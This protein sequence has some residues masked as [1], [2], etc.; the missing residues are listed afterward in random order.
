MGPHCVHRR[1]VLHVLGCVGG[2]YVAGDFARCARGFFRAKKRPPEGGQRCGCG[3]GG[4]PLRY[5]VK[6][7]IVCAVPVLVM[8]SGIALL[9]YAFRVQHLAGKV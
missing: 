1:H 5:V 7:A 2:E 6:Q 3:G 9:V 8:Q 4:L